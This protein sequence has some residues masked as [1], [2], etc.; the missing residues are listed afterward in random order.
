MRHFPDVKSYI[1]S[2]PDNPRYAMWNGP[3]Q[4]VVIARERTDG[5]VISV[6]FVPPSTRRAATTPKRPVATRELEVA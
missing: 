2:M 5:A 1:G 3:D 4:W 6:Q